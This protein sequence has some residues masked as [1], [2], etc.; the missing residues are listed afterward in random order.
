MLVLNTRASGAKARSI[1]LRLG[2]D[3]DDIASS[4]KIPGWQFLPTATAPQ[5]SLSQLTPIL[6]EIDYV[7]LSIIE[8]MVLV[9][10]YD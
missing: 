9:E 8:Q 5:D 3:F 10:Y 7:T 6:Y 1:C 2:P 4:S